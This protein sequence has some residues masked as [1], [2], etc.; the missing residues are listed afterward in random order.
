MK[1]AKLRR[2]WELKEDSTLSKIYLYQYKLKVSQFETEQVK[3][4]Q[5]LQD[6]P[7]KGIKI[8]RYFSKV[9]QIPNL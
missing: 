5:N 8:K 1:L 7:N 9:L 3:Y 4:L 6:N 2:D